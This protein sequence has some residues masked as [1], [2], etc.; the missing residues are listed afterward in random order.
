[1]G[2]V[3]VWV[4]VCVR[5]VTEHHQ[6]SQQQQTDVH[7]LFHKIIH[8]KLNGFE[9]IYM[10]GIRGREGYWPRGKPY[11]SVTTVRRFLFLLRSQAVCVC[12]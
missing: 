3:F 5:S 1:M 4:C 9:T 7:L 12:V 8:G 6:I 2:Y 10:G 11:V